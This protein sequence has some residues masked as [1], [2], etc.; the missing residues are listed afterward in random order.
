MQPVPI[1]KGANMNPKQLNPMTS[2]SPIVR[3][4]TWKVGAVALAA[5][6]AMAL[7]PRAAYAAPAP[8]P[9]S[10][11]QLGG[12]VAVQS[13][14]RYVTLHGSHVA[15]VQTANTAVDPVV[16][17]IGKYLASHQIL[18]PELSHPK[19]TRP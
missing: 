1:Q 5:A 6:L 11:P 7:A 16:H 9:L 4:N 12:E 2:S 14:L 18:W 3:R 17:N 10:Q 13:V 19:S 15:G 8:A